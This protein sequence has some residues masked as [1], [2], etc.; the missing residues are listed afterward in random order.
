MSI[1]ETIKDGLKVVQATD[2]LPLIK[3]LYGHTK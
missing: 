1:Y 2:N 3:K